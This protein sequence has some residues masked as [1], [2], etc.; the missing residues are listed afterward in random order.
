[1]AI[2][3]S[4][5]LS[6]AEIRAEFGGGTPT[7]LQSYY[8][9]GGLVP[10]SAAN[11]NIPTAGPIN[12]LQFY[13]ASNVDVT[14]DYILDWLHCNPNFTATNGTSPT[15][16]W[17]LNSASVSGI[18]TPI[19]VNWRFVNISGGTSDGTGGSAWAAIQVRQVRAGANV[20]FATAMSSENSFVMDTIPN[21]M[22]LQNGDMLH[23]T[24]T[25]GGRAAG[26]LDGI[27]GTIS[28]YKSCDMQ[29][30]N[31]SDGNAVVA[32][33]NYYGDY[34][35]TYWPGWDGGDGPIIRP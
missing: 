9:G 17:V 7:S 26:P 33:I 35:D 6:I 22:I 8:R 2:K 25:V 3:T 19:T 31:K 23:F 20:A 15:P 21:D 12:I 24:A 13:G 16:N 10:N 29:M 28:K 34:S 18:D 32:N 14:P 1:M 27:Q 5:P 4:G 30:F 11:S